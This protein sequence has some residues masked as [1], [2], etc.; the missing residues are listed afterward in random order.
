MMKEMTLI[1]DA[2]IIFEKENIKLTNIINES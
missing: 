1:N 2:K